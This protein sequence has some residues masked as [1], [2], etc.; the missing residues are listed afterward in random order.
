MFFNPWPLIIVCN[1]FLSLLQVALATLLLNLA[2]AIKGIPD[3]LGRAQAVKAACVMLPRLS[4]TE[5][6][7]RGLVALGTLIWDADSLQDKRE[8]IKSVNNLKEFTALLDKLSE[9]SSA[10]KVTQCATQ[11]SA[12]IQ[13]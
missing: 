1:L 7:F 3:P 12:L 10:D 6:L 4:D 8:L 11:V 9:G 5:A 2:V 13:V